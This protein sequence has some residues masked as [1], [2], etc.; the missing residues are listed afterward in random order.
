MERERC[1]I[2]CKM[3]GGFHIFDVDGLSNGFSQTRNNQKQ[4]Q[5]TWQT[6][7]YK[8]IKVKNTNNSINASYNTKSISITNNNNCTNSH[9]KSE[10]SN[11]HCPQSQHVDRNIYC[12][13]ERRSRQ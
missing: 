2:Y 7:S 1:S 6:G 8:V 13:Q 11:K 4:C 5:L 12:S 3:L 10:K 9:K